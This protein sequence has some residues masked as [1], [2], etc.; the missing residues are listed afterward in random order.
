MQQIADVARDLYA[1]GC[2]ELPATFQRA[3]RR[4]Q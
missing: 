4:M 2:R 3:L 1:L